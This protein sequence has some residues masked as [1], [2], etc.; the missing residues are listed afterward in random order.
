MIQLRNRIPDIKD[1]VYVFLACVFPIHLWALI[2]FLRE[3]PSYILWVD[4]FEIYSIFSYTQAIALVESII[5][6]GLVT[7]IAIVLPKSL[8]LDHYPSQ[9]TINI[10]LITIVIISYHYRERI[11]SASMAIHR[12]SIFLLTILLILFFAISICL[13]LFSKFE[14]LLVALL[15]SVSILSSIY[16]IIS[17]IG[18]FF[19][20]VRIITTYILWIIQT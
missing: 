13:R 6:F 19:S 10:L 15:K 16:L 14:H 9:S 1:L 2:Q 3:I 12:Q 18:F 8:I 7:T 5:F 20:A 17:I 11:I 4:W